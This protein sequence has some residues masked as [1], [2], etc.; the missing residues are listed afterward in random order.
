MPKYKFKKED[1]FLN[2]VVTKPSYNINF[3]LNDAYVNERLEEG[4]VITGPSLP[5][6]DLYV[7]PALT[8]P[9]ITI[10]GKNLYLS[11]VIGGVAPS[12]STNQIQSLTASFP[13][14]TTIKRSIFLKNYFSSSLSL[15]ASGIPGVMD[16]DDVNKITS[17]RNTLNYYKIFSPRYDYENFVSL[18]ANDEY[19]NTIE[20]VPDFINMI[21]IP[22][23]FY[24]NR[25]EPGSVK[26]KFYYTGSLVAEANDKY[27]DGVLYETTG[28][29][30]GSHIGVIL[31]NEGLI[32]VT[33]SYDLGSIVDGYLSPATTGE[34]DEAAWP[35]AS[36]TATASWAH[37][38]A[39]KSFVA[40][41]GSS[42]SSFGPTSSSYILEFEGNNEIPSMTYLAHANK[43]DLN[44]SNNPTYVERDSLPNTNSYANSYVKETG[45]Y[46]YIE[47][48]DLTIKNTVSSS[49]AYHSASYKPQTFITHIHLYDKDGDVIGIA[50]LANPVKK[51]DEQDYTFKIKL[52]M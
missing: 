42:S 9:D 1:K 48:P 4:G 37:F 24:G 16:G 29:N 51:T 13:F 44:W 33:A 28:S 11:E 50:K 30:S 35:S 19:G 45:S 8:A 31:Y 43:N 32:L 6:Y 23:L 21:E 52:D 49:F 26:L 14:K 41:T 47:N 40:S 36:Y 10:D 5:I 25:I 22:N 17:L 20:M 18:D 12:S 39:Y 15:S 34:K 38:G 46:T 3:Y 27:N 2:Y 7:A